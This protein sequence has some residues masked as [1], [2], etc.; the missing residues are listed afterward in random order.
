MNNTESQIPYDSRVATHEHRDE[1]AAQIMRVVSLLLERAAVHD[2]SKLVAPELE[3][4]DRVTPKLRGLT[5]GSEEYKAAL[6]DMGDGLAH[7]YAANRHHPEHFANGIQGMNLIDLVEMFCDWAAATKRHADGDLRR[8]IE[9]NQVRFGYS[10]DL[11]SIFSNTV[12]VEA[13]GG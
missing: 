11:K 13:L 3:V 7:H 1:V 12:E 8:S 9:Q 6:A 4:F 2:N 10:D 5:Y